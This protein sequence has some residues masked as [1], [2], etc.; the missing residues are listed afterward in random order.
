MTLGLKSACYGWTGIDGTGNTHY[1]LDCAVQPGW[2]VNPVYSGG[3]SYPSDGG[4]NITGNSG[5]GVIPRGFTSLK[6]QADIISWLNGNTSE[7]GCTGCLYN[8]NCP[9]GQCECHS[10]SYPGY[11]CNDCASTAAQIQSITNQLRDK[12]NAS[13]LPTSTV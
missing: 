2:T 8:G 7:G 13:Q 9:E 12:I 5:Y 6:S 1:F 3:Y 10:D 11:C 4:A